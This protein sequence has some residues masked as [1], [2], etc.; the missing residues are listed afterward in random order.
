MKCPLCN[1]HSTFLLQADVREYWSCE[2]W[3]GNYKAD[4]SLDMAI[5]QVVGVELYLTC[6]YLSGGYNHLKNIRVSNSIYF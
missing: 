2:K 4:I 1:Y 6:F 5:D 3:S